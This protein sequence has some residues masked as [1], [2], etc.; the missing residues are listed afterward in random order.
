DASQF[1]YVVEARQGRKI[2]CVEEIA[3]RNGW[4]SDAE[5]SDLADP[6]VKSG[7]GTY[8]HNILAEGR[9]RT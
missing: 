5:F 4:L 8:M 9:T 6:L 7:Y 1:V 3:W 2:G